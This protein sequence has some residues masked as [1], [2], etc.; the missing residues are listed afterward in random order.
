MVQPLNFFK[1]KI[2]LLIRLGVSHVDILAHRPIEVTIHLAGTWTS[3]ASTSSIIL[4][5]TD[6]PQYMKVNMELAED[7]T[8]KPRETFDECFTEGVT[9]QKKTLLASCI[10]TEM[11]SLA[12]LRI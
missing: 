9:R 12:T 10:R 1:Y 3:Q 5:K 11:F 8:A 6:R 4:A 2:S 7:R